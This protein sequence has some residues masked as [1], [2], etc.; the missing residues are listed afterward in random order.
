M[1]NPFVDQSRDERWQTAVSGWLDQL[2]APAT[3]QWLKDEAKPATMSLGTFALVSM[4]DRSM[5]ANIVNGRHRD[6]IRQYV[7]T[8]P[9]LL[10]DVMREERLLPESGAALTGVSRPGTRQG[11]A[12]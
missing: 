4:F 8:W 2:R 9:D 7:R 6:V 12:R 1:P 11:A 5:I 3:L 10:T